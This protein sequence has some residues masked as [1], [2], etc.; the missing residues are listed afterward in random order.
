MV[1][2]YSHCM[3]LHYSVCDYKPKIGAQVLAEES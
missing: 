1:Y 3:S 2:A